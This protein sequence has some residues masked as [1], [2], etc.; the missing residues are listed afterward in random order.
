[1]AATYLYG[2]IQAFN[3]TFDKNEGNIV[4]QSRT[5][6]SLGISLFSREVDIGFIRITINCNMK[7]GQTLSNKFFKKDVL[8]KAKLFFVFSSL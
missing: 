4:G 7:V 3:S 2:I 6:E 5:I 1:M 8:N